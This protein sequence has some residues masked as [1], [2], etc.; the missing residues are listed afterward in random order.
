MEKEEAIRLKHKTSIYRESIIRDLVRHLLK[1]TNS[2]I[3]YDN[4]FEIHNLLEPISMENSLYKSYLHT[5]P[6]DIYIFGTYRDGIIDY[7]IFNKRSRQ[8][9]SNFEKTNQFNNILKIIKFVFEQMEKTLEKNI[10]YDPL[11]IY[12]SL[13]KMKELDCY[14]LDEKVWKE[15]ENIFKDSY[16]RMSPSECDSLN[17]LYNNFIISQITKHFEIQYKLAEAFDRIIDLNK[18]DY[19][20]DIDYGYDI[21][22]IVSKYGKWFGFQELYH[23][24]YEELDKMLLIIDDIYDYP[25]GRIQELSISELLNVKIE[26]VLLRIMK[27]Q[28]C[29][30]YIYDEKNRRR[31][32]K[33]IFCGPQCKDLWWRKKR[34][35]E[36]KDKEY[37]NYY[38][39]L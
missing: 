10:A 35:K 24:S 29:Q 36:G 18:E 2:E 33:N 20:S 9:I 7:E 23:D 38:K 37:R 8:L 6:F 15:M 16:K 25:G 3:C 14:I 19:D 28:E 1:F 4:F 5:Y 27:C 13:T 31:H 30:K 39:T 34:K 17:C 26:N 11:S 21:L 32:A 12:L 22:W